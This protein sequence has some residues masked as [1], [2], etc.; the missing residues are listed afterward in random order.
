MWS[1][2]GVGMMFFIFSQH[3]SG[4]YDTLYKLLFPTAFQC[5]HRPYSLVF[6]YRY[7]ASVHRL[8]MGDRTEYSIYHVSPRRLSLA[9]L[10]ASRGP[11]SENPPNQTKPR[12]VKSARGGFPRKLGEDTRPTRSSVSHYPPTSPGFLLPLVSNSTRP[13]QAVSRKGDQAS[14]CH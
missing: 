12:G 11:S 8:V 3:L 1:R 6:D 5:F 7:S 4:L 9:N 13:V 10:C 2:D 14:C